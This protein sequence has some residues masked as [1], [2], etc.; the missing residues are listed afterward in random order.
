MKTHNIEGMLKR[1][2][3]KY[4][5][6]PVNAPKLLTMNCPE[7]I[8]EFWNDI[9]LEIKSLLEELKMK[10]KKHAYGMPDVERNFG[11]NQ[12]V[13]DQNQKINSLIK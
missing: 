10:E 11:Y 8:D 1:L 7:D 6:E 2:K 12:A 3:E 13:Q 9:S 4:E 5:E